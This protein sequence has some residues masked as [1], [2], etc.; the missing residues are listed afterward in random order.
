METNTGSCYMGTGTRTGSYSER[1]R[2]PIA[3]YRVWVRHAFNL[4]LVRKIR[5]LNISTK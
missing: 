5:K 1:V 4:R 2:E 3:V